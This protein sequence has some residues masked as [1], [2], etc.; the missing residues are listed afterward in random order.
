MLDNY[1]IP[2]ILCAMRKSKKYRQQEVAKF[3]AI[4]QSE[5]SNF[6][7]NKVDV[8]LSTLERIANALDMKIIAVPNQKLE[9]INRLL[10]PEDQDGKKEKPIT[11]LE[12][13]GVPDDE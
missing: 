10:T 7:N 13:Y 4:T 5:L 2:Q 11:L 12:K 3:C 1:S 9:K 8:R 6:E